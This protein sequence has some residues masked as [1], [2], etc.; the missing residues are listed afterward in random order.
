M[1]SVPGTESVPRS[2]PSVPR[3]AVLLAAFNGAR[4]I[5]A[6]VASINDQELVEVH[7]FISVDISTDA[8]RDICNSLAGKLGNVTVLPDG[9][10]FGSAAAN[11]YH[12]IQSVD[13]RDFDYVAL[14]DQDDIWRPDKLA[15]AVAEMRAGG[16]DAAS[17]DVM[18]FWEDGRRKLV[19]KSYPQK[20]FDF[21]FEAGGPGCSYVLTTAA[22]DRFRDFLNAHRAEIPDSLAHDWLIYAFCRANGLRWHIDNRIGV[23]Y[24]Q[25]SANQLGAN[26]GLAAFR[27]RFLA[28]YD[29]M[30]RANVMHL[31]RLVDSNS[32]IPLSDQYTVLL[33][34]AFHLRR[35]P[36]DALLLIFLIGLGLY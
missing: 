22:M 15:H 14:S 2:W 21:L 36:R 28:V 20:R 16:F 34:N 29:G 17:C 23:D 31:R 12:L 3:C 7:I 35:R 24:R 19:K 33:R 25:H 6:Q 9:Q 8:T 13:F 27:K 11:F 30:Y 26:L 32:N 4:W 18:A 1:T 10:V 5:E